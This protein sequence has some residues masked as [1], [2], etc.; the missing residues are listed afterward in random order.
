MNIF[1]NKRTKVAQKLLNKHY[2]IDTCHDYPGD[3]YYPGFMDKS[4]K[5]QVSHHEVTLMLYERFGAWD[6]CK[7]QK[8]IFYRN[9]VRTLKFKKIMKYIGL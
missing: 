1:R 5:Y 9:K 4:T 2:Y 6:W 7:K 8:D 3:I